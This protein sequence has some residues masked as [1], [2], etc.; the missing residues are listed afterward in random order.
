[1]LSVLC[2]WWW[3][4]ILNFCE[5][6][7]TFL[8]KGVRLHCVRVDKNE[9]AFRWRRIGQVNTSQLDDAQIDTPVL[10]ALCKR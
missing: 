9:K 2:C 1:M 7:Q 5:P 10:L 4:A 3:L 6:S 8:S